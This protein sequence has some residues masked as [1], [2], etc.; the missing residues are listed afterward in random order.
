[1]MGF[2]SSD[3]LKEA[4]RKTGVDSDAFRQK[5]RE[6]RIP[7]PPNLNT[8]LEVKYTD[9]SGTPFGYG[10]PSGGSLSDKTD[11]SGLV[12]QYNYK[13]VDGQPKWVLSTL[14][15]NPTRRN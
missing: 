4:L 11:M 9:P 1:M 14:Y 5:L 2:F 10:I 3:K 7:N 8:T 13:L 15:P 12:A 6:R